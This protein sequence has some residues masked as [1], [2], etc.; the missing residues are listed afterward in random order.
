MEQDPRVPIRPG[1][2]SQ[3]DYTTSPPT[4]GYIDEAGRVRPGPVPMKKF[5]HTTFCKVL[6]EFVGTY[7]L[8]FVVGCNVL[9]NSIGAA[10]SIGTMLMVM[11]YALGSVSGAHFNPAVTV[12][13]W[14]SRRGLLPFGDA[15]LYVLGQIG[16]GF[17]AA[18]SYWFLFGHTFTIAPVGQYSLASAMIVEILYTLALCYVVLNVTT[19]RKQDGSNYFGLAIGFTIV[20]AALTIG[21]I[22]GCVLNPAVA[23]GCSMVA[24]LHEGTA[25]FSYTAVYF[26]VP[27]VGALLADGAF[28]VVQKRD[29]Y[30]WQNM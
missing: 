18:L 21:G 26:L 4:P 13:I 27:F 10:L 7:Y 20:S 8:V 28:F 22:S 11:I 12:A 5:V 25:A 14:G 23:L 24:G 29:E 6:A 17:C 15:C 1:Y 16:G 3:S 9:T 2:G 19:T 30:N